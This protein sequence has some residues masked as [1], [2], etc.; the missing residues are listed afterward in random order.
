MDIGLQIRKIRER[1]NLTQ[2]YMATRLQ[3]SKTS[4]GNI[5]RNMIKRVPLPML[6]AIAELLHVHY[7]ALLGDDERMEASGMRALLDGMQHLL[8]KMD[9]MEKH[10]RRLQ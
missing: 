3:I 5:E 6:M 2:E 9:G 1:S 10:L 4:Y 8:E 7:T